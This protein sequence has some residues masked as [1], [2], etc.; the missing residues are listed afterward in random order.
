MSA[1]DTLKSI[2]TYET[3]TIIGVLGIILGFIIWVIGYP[4]IV[5]VTIIFTIIPAILLVIPSET[6]KNSKILGIIFIILLIVGIFSLSSSYNYIPGDFY[7]GIAGYY[8]AMETAITL[9]IILCIYS[10]FCAVL[11]L[12][13]SEHKHNS[14]TS[15]TQVITGN[16]EK[17]Y[18]K[19]CSECGEGLFKNSKFCPS[20]GAK[21]DDF[22]DE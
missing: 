2:I 5:L 9:Q 13:P 7:T 8:Y 12:I 20:C 11:L 15:S 6:I 19:F 4:M 21:I 10:L 14:V 22:K 16:N 3:K 18:D 1:L 17:K